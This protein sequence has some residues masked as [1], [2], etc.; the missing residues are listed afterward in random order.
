MQSLTPGQ[1]VVIKI[2]H[3]ELVALMGSAR[4][5]GAEALKNPGDVIPVLMMAGLQGAG[6]TTTAAKLAGKLKSKRAVRLL[7]AACDVYR[8]AAV[9]AAAGQRRE[10]GRR[11]VFTMG[12][13]Q[14]EAG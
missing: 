9:E 1:Q 8:P 12:T 5:H 10:A 2:V 6:K 11:S 14:S 13:R 4:Q 7:L 3:E